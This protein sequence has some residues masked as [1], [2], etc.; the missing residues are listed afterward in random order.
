[1]R[2]EIETLKNRGD[3]ETAEREKCFKGLIKRLVENMAERR[4]NSKSRERKINNLP[5]RTDSSSNLNR[6]TFS[7]HGQEGERKRMA[8]KSWYGDK[9]EGKG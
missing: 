6:I 2:G 9:W 1:L 3:I 5:N 8:K 4:K 7:I